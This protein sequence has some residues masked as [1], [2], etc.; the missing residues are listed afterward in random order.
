MEV[1]TPYDHARPSVCERRQCGAVRRLP[2]DDLQGTIS[3]TSDPSQ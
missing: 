2:A 1:A 3:L